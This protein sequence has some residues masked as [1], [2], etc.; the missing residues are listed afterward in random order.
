MKYYRIEVERTYTTEVFVKCKDE[1][2]V[3]NVLDAVSHKSILFNAQ[4]NLWDYILDEETQQC[5]ITEQA[6][7]V[8][9][10]VINPDCYFDLDSEIIEDNA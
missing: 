5:Y 4:T 10:K 3:Q 8:L 2:T 1:D 9:D 6:A 7:T